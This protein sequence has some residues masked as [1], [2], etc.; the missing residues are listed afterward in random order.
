MDELIVVADVSGSMYAAGK[1]AIL[2]TTMQTISALGKSDDTVKD[3]TVTKM[4]WDGNC[5]SFESLAEKCSG[6]KTLIL[7]DG[8]SFLDNCRE[9]QPTKKFFE[10]DRENVFVVL[11][12]GDAVDISISVFPMLKQHTIKAENILFALE[13]LLFKSTGTELETEKESWE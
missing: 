9:S 2:G 8:Y 4:Q 7:T 13:S 11:C 1:P 6:T 12:G 3:I 5:K 10:T